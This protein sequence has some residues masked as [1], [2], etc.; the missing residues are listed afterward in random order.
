MRNAISLIVLAGLAGTASAQIAIT[1][2][3]YSANFAEYVEFTNVSNAPVDMTGWSY[4]DVSREPGTLD[5]SAFGVVAPGESVIITEE[6][7]DDF[8]TVWGLSGVKVI[9]EY[10]NNL[11][12]G[13]EINL[14]DAGDNLV[15]QLTYGDEDF[16]GTIRAQDFSGNPMPGAVGNND[17]AGWVLAFEGDS[18]GSFLSAFGDVGNPGTYIPAPAPIALLGLGGLIALRRR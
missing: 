5:L 14:Y 11:G 13:D 15:D 4:D 6:P 1:E 10:T 16:P 8:I 12:R 7:A 18:F 3:M 17:I 2:Y 9:G